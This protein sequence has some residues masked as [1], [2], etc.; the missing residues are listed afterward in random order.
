MIF[1]QAAF[2]H[3]LDEVVDGGALGLAVA[4]R[5]AQVVIGF[6]DRSVLAVRLP[7]RM[8]NVWELLMP[9]MFE[10]LYDAKRPMKNLHQK[11]RRVPSHVTAANRTNA[12]ETSF[13][14]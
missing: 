3:L 5:P 11:W 6:V 2:V 10:N 7:Y 12:T 8:V 14:I 4:D 13:T 1:D 9:L